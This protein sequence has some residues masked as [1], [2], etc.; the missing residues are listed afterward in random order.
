MI[1]DKTALNSSIGALKLVKLVDKKVM[2]DNKYEIDI[3][4]F[5]SY[6]CTFHS[7]N[8][9]IAHG[10]VNFSDDQRGLTLS[11][12][13]VATGE[14]ESVT[15]TFTTNNK[16]QVWLRNVTDYTRIYGSYVVI[17]GMYIV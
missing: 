7:A 6:L 3:A 13:N 12:Y 8:Y 2:D 5:P 10:I 1:L 15:L 11:L 16:V 9:D 17:Y 4:T 14:E